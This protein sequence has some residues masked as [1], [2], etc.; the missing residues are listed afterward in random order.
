[1]KALTTCR[2]NDQNPID[3]FFIVTALLAQTLKSKGVPLESDPY[4]IYDEFKEAAPDRQR[5]FLNKCQFYIRASETAIEQEIEL[6]QDKQFIWNTVKD[7][8]L[9]LPSDVFEMITDHDEVEIYD[10]RGIQVFANFEFFRKVSYTPEEMYWRSWADLFEREQ[11]HFDQLMQN[12]I[13]SITEAT[14]P[15]K[16]SV[17][18]H[19][20]WETSSRRMKKSWVEFKM[21][22][23]IRSRL[24]NEKYMIASSRMDLV[25][26]QPF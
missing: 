11:K 3:E 25:F 12:F 2:S 22:A 8:G 4:Q 20:A 23:P 14:G 1:M 15:F 6:L 17:D 5:D 9:V 18:K 10:S 21:F 7:M 19:L 16:P 13:Y 26:E 24:T